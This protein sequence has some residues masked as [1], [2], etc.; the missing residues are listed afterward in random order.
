MKNKPTRNTKYTYFQ[1]NGKQNKNK[2]TNRL[3]QQLTNESTT[4]TKQKK[5]SDRTARDRQTRK[6]KLLD[7]FGY[8]WR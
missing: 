4:Q 6:P 1:L 7:L 3:E 2:T 8:K 5:N